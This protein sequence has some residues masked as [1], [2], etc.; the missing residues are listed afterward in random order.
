M[1][2]AYVTFE[3]PPF[4]IGGAGIHAKF[5]TRELARRGHEIIVFTPSLDQLMDKSMSNDENSNIKVVRVPINNKIPFRA[6]QFWIRLPGILKLLEKEN[7][8]DIIHFNGISYWFLKRK[9]VNAPHILTVHHLVKDAV[10]STHQNFFERLKNISGETGFLLPLIEKKCIR[11]VDKIIS[12]SKFTQE[13]IIQTYKIDQSK[14]EVVYNGIDN[15]G[16]TFSEQDLE[17]IKLTYG[18][19]KKPIILFVGRIDDPRKGLDVL[20][21]A[22]KLI[23]KEIDSQLVIVGKGNHTIYKNLVDPIKD[24]IVF[25]G[26]IDDNTLKKIYSI[27][28]VYVCPSRL[29]GFGLTILEALAAGKPVIATNVGAIPELIHEGIN[30]ILVQKDDTFAMASAI[31]Y[32]LKNPVIL[33]RNNFLNNNFNKEFTWHS[34][35]KKHERIYE[36]MV[37]LWP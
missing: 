7:K 27:C 15:S 9:I 37:T 26:Y 28:D 11:S 4:I 5:V 21:K 29:E 25:T 22:F 34:T 19:R 20:I 23:L 3:Y 10:F 17:K 24:K 8:F 36:T 16:F 13:Q 6:L 1:K 35:A 30:G 33:K 12:V 32:F 14:I 31:I 2:I 18:M